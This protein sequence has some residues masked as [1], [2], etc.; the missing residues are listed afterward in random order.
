MPSTFFGLEIGMRGLMTQQQAIDVTGQNLTNSSTAGYSRQTVT[1]TQTDPYPYPAFNQGQLAGQMGTGAQV[2][3]VVRVTDQLLNQQIC[4]QTSSSGYW[5]AQQDIMGQAEQI[6]NEPTDSNVRTDLDNYWTQLQGLADDPSNSSLRTTLI[7]AA[8]QL[9][10]DI[11]QGYQ[12]LQQLQQTA[13]TEVTNTV[14]EINQY[15]GQIAG[16]NQQIGQV[17]AVGDNANDLM[18]QRDLL[19][20]KLSNDI[21]CSESTDSTNN[22]V[23]LS[24]YGIPLVSG[25]LTDQIQTVS[26]P[27]NNGMAQLQWTEPQG[28]AVQADNGSLAGY[29]QN[30]DQDL[31][32][33]M[34]QLNAVAQTLITQTNAVYQNGYD[35]NG[36]QATSTFFS[37]TGAA[38][39]TLAPALQDPVNGPNLIAASS[40]PSTTGNGDIINQ[41]AALKDA[42]LLNNNTV[43]IEDYLGDMVS[44]L[45]TQSQT[46]QDN[47]TYQTDLLN[48]LS[49][50]Q[51]SVSGVNTDEEST[52]LIEYQ[53]AYNA[54]AKVISTQDQM[55]QEIINLQA[56]PD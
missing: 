43:S 25:N 38:D 32:Q 3:E 21:N 45:G 17:T 26:D 5:T 10:D 28:L 54:A 12:S 16:L 46:A 31:P 33:A 44:T 7:N 53:N 49:N 13:N 39:I 51:Q 11:R 35:M 40:D 15:A 8:T 6:V 47:L 4:Q 48:N 27:N 2:T 18:D 14:T 34:N 30:R 41:M 52:N 20:A 56:N 29:L 23:T 42:P 22:E 1:I 24:V 19:V 9:T 55:L 37:G 36:N 50:L